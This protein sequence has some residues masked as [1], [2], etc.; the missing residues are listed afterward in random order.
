MTEA[1]KNGSK[2]QWKLWA[3]AAVLSILAAFLGVQW[4]SAIDAADANNAKITQLITVH[5]SDFDKINADHEIDIARLDESNRNRRNQIAE[6]EARIA[7]LEE[8]TRP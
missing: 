3:V 2:G 7:T 1:P 8:R 4:Q 5:E 6:L